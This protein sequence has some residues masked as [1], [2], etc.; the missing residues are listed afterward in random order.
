MLC[1]WVNL[2]TIGKFTLCFYLCMHYFY[3]FDRERWKVMLY[4][5]K[6]EVDYCS[7]WRTSYPSII[8][9]SWSVCECTKLILWI[10]CKSEL[11][12]VPMSWHITPFY[13]HK[14]L[15]K[16]QK[17]SSWF[18]PFALRWPVVQKFTFECLAVCASSILGLCGFVPSVFNG[19]CHVPCTA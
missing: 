11:L 18:S 7:F 17:G 2:Y 10:M 1:C 14:L 8:W 19:T 15:G 9:D 5:S 3:V 6:Y 16:L 13:R 12:V 4:L